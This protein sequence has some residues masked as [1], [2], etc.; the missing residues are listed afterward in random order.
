MTQ[1]LKRRWGK[2][3]EMHLFNVV[4]ATLLLLLA[5]LSGYMWVALFLA[6]FWGAVMMNV[7]FLWCVNMDMEDHGFDVWN[8]RW[9][10]DVLNDGEP[11][12]S[13][14]ASVQP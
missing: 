14:D 4:G 12:A 13:E 10:D 7:T 2:S 1:I 8:G 5:I 9:Y 3:W 11:G 6:A